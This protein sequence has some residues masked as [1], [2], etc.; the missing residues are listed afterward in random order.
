MLDEDPLLEHPE[1]TFAQT[2]LNPPLLADHIVERPR[3]LH[4]LGEAVLTYRLVLI[5]APAGSGK[6]TLAASLAGADTQHQVAWI[7]LDRADND[8]VVFLTLVIMALRQPHPH[9]GE[10]MLDLLGH[11]PDAHTRLPQLVSFLINDILALGN[12]PC[13]L[14]L[15]DFHLIDDRS[16]YEL[17]V[18]LIDH[19]PPQLHLVI[20]SR[21]EPPLPLAR[22]R[23]R[24]QLAEF[25]LPDLRFDAAEAAAYYNQQLMLGLTPAELAALQTRTEGWIAGM[26]LLAMTLNN[27]DDPARRSA[28][29]NQLSLSNR[30]I[31]D[32]LADEVLA[33]Q[34]SELRDFLLQTSIL[35]FLTPTLC[36]A[37]TANSQAPRLLEEAYRRNL[38]LTAVEDGNSVDTAYRYHDLFAAFLQRRLEQSQPDLLP[39]LHQRA[40]AAQASREQAIH[41]L[42]AA[43]QW[44]AA[45]DQIEQQGR[46]EISRRFVRRRLA[47]WIL[48]LPESVRQMRPWLYLVLG[49]YWVGRGTTEQA[50]ATLQQALTLFREEEDEP[51]QIEVLVAECWRSGYMIT[52]AILEEL[53]AKIERS[54]QLVRPDQIA[55]YH[56]TAQWYHLIQVHD[57]PGVTRHLRASFDLA[58][59][60]GDLGVIMTVA[61]ACGPELLFNDQ[62]IAPLEAFVQW[63]LS[64]IPQQ[65]ATHRLLLAVPAYIH[66]YRAELD[67]AEAMIGEVD[68]YLKQIGGRA[69][70]DGH[71]SWLCL[72]LLRIR[73]NFPAIASTIQ[74]ARTSMTANNV[75]RQFWSGLVYLQ[76]RTAW[77]RGDLVETQSCLAELPHPQESPWY[78]TEDAI[79]RALLQGLLALSAR[80]FAQGEQYLHHAVELHR[81]V[82]H[83]MFLNDPRLVLAI[84]YDA[85]HKPEDALAV[86]EPALID[87]RQRGMPGVI[88]Q[89]GVSILPLMR[90]ALAQGIEGDLLTPLIGILEGASESRSLLIPGSTEMLSPREAEVLRLLTAGESNREIAAELVITERTVKAHVTHILGKLGVT[91]RTQ[92]V[93]RSRE[94]HLL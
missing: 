68:A 43:H 30:L 29:I 62:G 35:G 38:F 5:S 93:A 72:S 79:R 89:E 11:L 74:E 86:L 10:T 45:A 24:G 64:R 85:W 84:L 14:V 20:T 1:R 37:V 69:W 80:Q 63:A 31:F 49:V 56:A 22:W 40:A 48:A 33:Y 51:G 82:R 71:V 8:P 78:T 44:E 90:M 87:I 94:L 61:G 39:E 36:A 92:A 91:S 9:L 34:P 77:E 59:Q 12:T 46:A 54:P 6:S 53:A 70:M 75:N 83:T 50:E 28:F 3:L 16:V 58:Q 81:D 60:T 18:D 73:R 2:R 47:D 88:L 67:Q 52:P 42:L 23:V 65:Q 15:D 19:A 13:I 25:H 4:Q 32:L 41:H 26:R 21:Y 57:W 27:L 55:G 76:G 66:F 7:T 17:L